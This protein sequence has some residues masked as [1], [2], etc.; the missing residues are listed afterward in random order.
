MQSGLTVL[1]G[2]R[3]ASRLCA[4]RELVLSRCRNGFAPAQENLAWMY[5]AAPGVSLDYSK[6]TEWVLAEAVHG[7]ARAELDLGYLYG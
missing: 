6:A 7:Y 5:Y 4:D 3:C 2:K 1:S